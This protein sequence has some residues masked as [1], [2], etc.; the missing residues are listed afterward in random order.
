MTHK[1]SFKKQ[2]KILSVPVAALLTATYIVSFPSN[3]SLGTAFHFKHKK[4]FLCV[5]HLQRDFLLGKL[6]TIPK[7]DNNFL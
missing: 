4:H 2:Q 7:I 1:T 5:L 3:Y 6:L